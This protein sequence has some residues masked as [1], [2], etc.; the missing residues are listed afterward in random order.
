MGGG[1]ASDAPR[2]TIEDD[3]IAGTIAVTIH[4]G[5][6][7]I[8]EDGRRLYAAETLRLTASDATP[9][10]A[11]LDADVVYR[12]AETGHAIEIRAHSLQ[13]SDVDAFDISVDLTV[14]L[15]S[16]RFFERTWRER[17]PRHL[18]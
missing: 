16:A 11:S 15:D 8:L 4:D 14:D 10:V 9:A 1:G 18:V 17:I 13:T 12:W 6:E 3:V 2:W 7:D 5:G